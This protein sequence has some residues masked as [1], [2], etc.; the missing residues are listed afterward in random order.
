MF[1]VHH[2]PKMD[3]TSNT[4]L[5]S[6]YIWLYLVLLLLPWILFA[7]M[8]Q[9]LQ[10]RYYD[11]SKNICSFSSLYWTAAPSALSILY[12]LIFLVREKVFPLYIATKSLKV[13]SFKL[14]HIH[15]AFNE[16][17][18]IKR[19]CWVFGFLVV[20]NVIVFIVKKVYED[21]VDAETI[22]KAT[23]RL[24]FTVVCFVV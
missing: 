5:H 4:P 20:V 6:G 23:I 17:K 9:F 13:F 16:W 1:L 2:Y 8:S 11:T 22:A 15:S 14:R 3:P 7:L 10:G 19:G 21:Q 18:D 24:F 12:V